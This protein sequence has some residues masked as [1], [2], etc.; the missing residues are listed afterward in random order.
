L[1]DVTYEG[2]TYQVHNHF[3]PFLVK[4]V[5]KW[6]IT[7]PDIKMTLVSAQ[8]TF[9]AKWIA[10]KKLSTEAEQVL[11]KGEEIYKYYFSN[12]GQ[13]PSNIYKIETW[14]AGWWQIKQSLTEVHLCKQ[15]LN[16]LKVLLNTL[17]DNILERL[18][19][20]EIIDG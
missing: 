19:E 15:E 7:D 10:S 3:F 6:T 14:D 18:I 2:Q 9:V 4:E 1:K 13:I 16:D 12:L 17:K 11:K 8:D 20:Y 5:K